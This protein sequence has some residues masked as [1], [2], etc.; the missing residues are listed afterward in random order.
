MTPDDTKNPDQITP[1]TPQDQQTGRHR[2]ER[3][4]PFGNRLRA[5][6][7][8]ESGDRSHRVAPKMRSLQIGTAVAAFGVLG[9]FTA[10]AGGEDVA[11]QSAPVHQAAEVAPLAAAPA[12]QHPVPAPA[13]IVQPQAAPAPVAQPAPV[14]LPAPLAESVPAPAAVPAPEEKPKDQVDAWIKEAIKVLERHGVSRD[15]IDSEAIRTI[16]MKESNG[17]PSATN[18]WDSNAAAGTPSI[19]LMQTIEPTFQSFAVPG[20]QNIYDPVDN[21]VA[22]TR[23]SIDRYGS[24]ADVPGVSGLRSGGSYQGY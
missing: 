19:G 20:H 23:Y 7:L 10:G 8:G 17:N 2:W 16:I 22:A 6:F 1:D 4:V 3:T 18:N 13:P 5:T 12:A 11:T 24:V 15:Q 14:D 21:I 9:V